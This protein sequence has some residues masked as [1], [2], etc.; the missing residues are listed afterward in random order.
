MK[1][2]LISALTTALVV[3]AAS[4]TFAAANP[5]ADVPADHWAYD[6]VAKLSEE[7]VVVGYSD[8]TYRGQ[9][10]IT[11]YEMA[12]IIA[13]AMATNQDASPATQALLDKLSAEFSDE[14]KTLGVRV[15][16]LEKKVGNVTWNGRFRYRFI[17][18]I[19]EGRNDGNTTNQALLRLEPTARINNH[20]VGKARI[21]VGQAQNLK[22]GT[23]DT[24]IATDRIYVVGTYGSTQITLG[25]F[26]QFT[27][28]DYGM[29]MD[30]RM[31]GGQLVV[32]KDL[33]VAVTGGRIYNQTTN[34]Y[35]MFAANGSV[36]GGGENTSDYLAAEIYNN[37]K[38]KFTYGVAYQKIDSRNVYAGEDK[39]QILSAGLG[40]KFTK[41]L[42]VTVAYSKAL[43][44]P[45]AASTD[46]ENALNAQLNWKGAVASKAGSYGLFV[47]YRDLGQYAVPHTTYIENG[48]VESG[49]RGFEIG[50][51]WTPAKNIVAKAQYFTGTDAKNGDNDYNAVWTE[52][53]FIF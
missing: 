34:G 15:S 35:N 18:K 33:K 17:K 53:S 28:A 5:F 19:N 31:T 49:M 29:T 45:D 3:G 47:A 23:N 11:R 39:A 20:W 21:D 43:D 38:D 42:N 7:G 46:E 8:G 1:K 2:S 44:A 37:R 16:A 52:V 51:S 27:Q 26:P 13:R 14:L 41:D 25:K 40:Y 4:T 50:G 36:P 6:A 22:T 32:G 10:N 24:T 12:A 9:Q 48:P 30:A